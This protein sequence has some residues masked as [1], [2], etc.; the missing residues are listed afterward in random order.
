MFKVFL[1]QLVIRFGEESWYLLMNLNDKPNFLS[2]RFSPQK[3]ES[4]RHLMQTFHC[5]VI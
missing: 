2:K 5:F 1:I 3:A 4:K